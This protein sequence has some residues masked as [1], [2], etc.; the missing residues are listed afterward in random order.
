MLNFILPILM[1]LDT[2][3]IIPIRVLLPQQIKTTMT[4]NTKKA[5]PETVVVVANTKAH[6]KRVAQK[7][8]SI[9]VIHVKE[10]AKKVGNQ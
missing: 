8:P 1:S 2:T 9:M 10:T 4:D 3:P 5:T 7:H 6:A